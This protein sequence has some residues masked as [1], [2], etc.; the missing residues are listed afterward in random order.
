M[1]RVYGEYNFDGTNTGNIVPLIRDYEESLKLNDV[2]KKLVIRKLGIKPEAAC[3]IEIDGRDFLV[4]EK[5]SLEF[6]Y[7]S[8]KVH[9]IVFKTL[10]VKAIVRYMYFRE[11][12]VY[13]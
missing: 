8:I 3:T 1:Q 6:G 7:D 13:Q 11:D 10:G 4:K 5:E 12:M 2:P 9:S